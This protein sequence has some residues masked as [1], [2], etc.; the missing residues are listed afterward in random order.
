MKKTKSKLGSVCGVPV[1]DRLEFTLCD[2]HLVTGAGLRQREI[3]FLRLEPKN[4][5]ILSPDERTGEY[6]LLQ[7]LLDTDCP[8]PSFLS[9]D[10]TEGLDDVKQYYE[11]LVQ[12]IP[13]QERINGEILRRLTGLEEEGT[14][15][16]T[17][18][19]HR[20]RWDISDFDWP[21]GQNC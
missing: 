9:M 16:T 14:A 19:S 11:E 13:A 6:R 17:T 4:M 10:K 20:W 7:A 2:D 15:R 8:T 3:Y 18:G 21:R 1:P 12:T 5:D